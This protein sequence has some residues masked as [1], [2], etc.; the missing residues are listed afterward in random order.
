MVLR[1]LRFPQPLRLAGAAFIL[2]AVALPLSASADPL[3]KEA[4]GKLQ[5]EKQALVVLGVDKEFAKGPEW[6]KANL[7]QAELNLLKR[8]LT[9]DEQLKFRCGMAMVNLTIP[10]DEDGP[11]EVVAPAPGRVPMPERREQSATVK[12]PAK[13]AAPV[14]TQ[15]AG[16]VK[17]TPAAPATPKAAP[18]AAPKAQ[19]SWNTE[20][21]P[22]EAT[23]PA[24]IEQ[25]EVREPKTKGD[26]LRTPQQGDRG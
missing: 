5:S 9:I 8:Y 6:A 3:D 20:T 13:P 23:S 19:S 15:P 11:D 14:Q 1:S 24:A 2:G 4:C 21:A 25:L 22:V 18:K 17:P 26:R 12:P 16:V 10:A 7:G